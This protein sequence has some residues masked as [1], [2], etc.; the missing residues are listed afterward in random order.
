VTPRVSIVLP[1]RN[2]A[3][4]LKGAIESCLSQTLTNLEI[5]VVDDG[6]EDSTPD[7]V[8]SFNDR[9]LIYLKQDQA[10]LPGA[11]NT[12][13]RQ[14]GGELLTWTSDDNRYHPNAIATMGRFL[15]IHPEIDIVYAGARLVDEAGHPLG[16]WPVAPPEELDRVNC[17]GACFLYKREVYERLGEY[18]PAWALVEDYEFWLRARRLFTLKAI[19]Q[20]LYDLCCHNDSLTSTRWV[21]VRLQVLKLKTKYVWRQVP[22][23]ERRKN[24]GAG[25]LLLSHILYDRNDQ[26]PSR[27]CSLLAFLADPFRFACC[28]AVCRGLFPRRI[29]TALKGLRIRLLLDRA[30]AWP[31]N[32]SR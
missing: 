31:N 23:W 27:R 1:T 9:R 29:W 2:R 5:I 18:D 7:V 16:N 3:G 8:M 19:D 24:L 26:L 32:S 30:Y 14:S 13:F 4:L 11:L 25:Y 20:P 12:G 17:V 22:F 15:E 21:D 10:G 28:K 6:S